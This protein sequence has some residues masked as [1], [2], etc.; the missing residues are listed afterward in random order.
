MAQ[1]ILFLAVTKAAVKV[2]SGKSWD[3]SS[4]YI[5]KDIYSSLYIMKE[6]FKM[7]E[8]AG[9]LTK[10]PHLYLRKQSLGN[11]LHI[12]FLDGV[13]QRHPEPRG[14]GVVFLLFKPLGR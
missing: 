13:L 5:L 3:I 10:G 1:P 8:Q 7:S 12:S 14:A 11:Y 4:H 9:S 2:A 6:R